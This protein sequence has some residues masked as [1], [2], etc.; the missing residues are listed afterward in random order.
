MDDLESDMVA[1]WRK[2][3]AETRKLLAAHGAGNA[4]RQLR[5]GEVAQLVEEAKR[6]EGLIKAFE[7][8]KE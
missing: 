3:L 4:P 5:P 8:E 7:A 2:E 6:Y 1:V